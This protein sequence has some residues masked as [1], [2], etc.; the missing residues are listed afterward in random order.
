MNRFIALED[1]VDDEGNPSEK[2]SRFY[3][4]RKEQNRT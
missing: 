2:K 3:Q 1:A 4:K